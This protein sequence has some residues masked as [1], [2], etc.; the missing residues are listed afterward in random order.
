MIYSPGGLDVKEGDIVVVEGRVKEYYGTTEIIVSS[1]ETVGKKKVEPLS[2]EI[3][4][5]GE[6]YEGVLVSIEGIIKSVV[7]YSFAVSDGEETI[8]IYIKKGT[9]IKLDLETGQ[10]VKVTGIVQSYKGTWE[11]L[12]RSPKDIQIIE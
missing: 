9:G 6:R 10:K 11:I 8:K 2:V 7:K 4:D 5:I 1:I 3:K 12:P